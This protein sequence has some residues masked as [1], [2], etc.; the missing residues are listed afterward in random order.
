[1]IILVK[2]AVLFAK[3]TELFFDALF[4]PI[5][6]QKSIADFFLI[7]PKLLRA[8]CRLL[9]FLKVFHML[10]YKIFFRKEPKKRCTVICNIMKF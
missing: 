6:L 8:F 2:R 3:F 7:F 4:L 5:F 1:M 10:L 9:P